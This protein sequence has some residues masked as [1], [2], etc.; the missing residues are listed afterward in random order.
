MPNQI[1]ANISLASLRQHIGAPRPVLTFDPPPGS[2]RSLTKPDGSPYGLAIRIE[3]PS[4]LTNVR[5]RINGGAWLDYDD[6]DRPVLVGT[7]LI[8]AV[9]GVPGSET[10]SP[11]ARGSYQIGGTGA[12]LPGNATDTNGNGLSDA[13]EKAFAISDPYAD[14]DGDGVDNLAEYTAGTDPRDPSSLPAGAVPSTPPLEIE[15]VANGYN[16]YWDSADSTLIL[17]FSGNMLNP[18][19]TVSGGAIT[20]VGLRHTHYVADNVALV[21]RFFRLRKP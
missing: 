11:T 16:V 8:E 20:V 9:G 6:N 17:E 3:N 4:G 14:T 5:Y 21:R 12:L 2:Y 19:T 7:S 1:R 15:R 10:A 13:W 18:W